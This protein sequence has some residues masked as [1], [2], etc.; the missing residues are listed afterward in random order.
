MI[1]VNDARKQA[2]V[3]KIVAACGGSLAGKD[4]GHP[5]P[6]LQAQ[7]RRRARGAKCRHRAGARG[8]G[9][10]GARLR[11]AGNGGGLQADAPAAI[12]ADPY[13]CI[14]GA[15]AMVILTEWDQF[16]ALDLDWVKRALRNPV[17]VDLRNIYQPSNMASK[18]FIYVGVGRG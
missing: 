17:V 15:D 18:G 10:A 9:C 3:K 11:S 2:M 7:Y 4:R 16:H 12:A 8:E 5:G 14:E 13:A 6:D 1:G